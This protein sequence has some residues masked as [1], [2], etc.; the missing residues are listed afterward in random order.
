MKRE[1]LFLSGILVLAGL[2]AVAVRPGSGKDIIT[3]TII[4]TK[5]NVCLNAFN[6]CATQCGV[7]AS[8]APGSYSV[9]MQDCTTQYT[10]C[11]NGVARL[12]PQ[13]PPPA[14]S[15]GPSI[16]PPKSPPRKIGP[17]RVDKV[18]TPKGPPTNTVRK[19]VSP[20]PRPSFSPSRKTSLGPTPA[21][22]KK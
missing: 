9:C 4:R 19:P 7:Q 6:T 10:R 14:V 21:A 8:A 15:P 22:A 17:E 5:V 12:V 2:A 11:M 13:A 18:K 20:T 16:A 3:D 1:R